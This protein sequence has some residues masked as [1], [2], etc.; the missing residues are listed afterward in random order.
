MEIYECK[1]NESDFRL[2]INLYV[3]L[4]Y[5][6]NNI[7]IIY[8]KNK[9]TFYIKDTLKSVTISVFARIILWTRQDNRIAIVTIIHNCWS[10]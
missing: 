3:L 4:N 1:E 2:K 6:N 8:N 9:T 7:I 5:N 10:V